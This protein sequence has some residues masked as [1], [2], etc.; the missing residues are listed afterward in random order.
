M[1]ATL[2]ATAQ[3]GFVPAGPIAFAGNAY[4]NNRRCLT[5]PKPSSMAVPL[6]P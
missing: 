6:V 4:F 3:D 5:A 2:S 1:A